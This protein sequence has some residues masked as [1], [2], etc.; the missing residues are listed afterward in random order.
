[1]DLHETYFLF[2][3]RIKQKYSRQI[4]RLSQVI[5]DRA[6]K[7]ALKD[8][9]PKLASIG[10][11]INL[12]DDKLSYV[13]ENLNEL[14]SF[15]SSKEI[16][17]STL[18]ILSSDH[19]QEFLDHGRVGHG[20]GGFYDEILHIPL[21]LF[22]PR[23]QNGVNRRLVSQL[24]IAPTILNFY[25]IIAPKD[26]RGN[27]VLSTHTNRFVISEGFPRQGP[28]YAIRTEKWK[29]IR[30]KRQRAQLYNLEEDLKETKN[31]IDEEGAEAK[32][33]ESIIEE[34]MLWEEKRRRQR[35][36]VY[37]QERIRRKIR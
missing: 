26:Y 30:A 28:I 21:I 29:Y 25:G 9:E 13:D 4:S 33:I 24:D 23:I 37:E 6:W 18:I 10:G 11:I 15:L 19:G 7:R 8:R 3:T 36:I 12:Y 17:D 5:L 1:M 20:S 2:N 31:V 27:N 14:F 35:A 34:H 16:V 32:E 22:G